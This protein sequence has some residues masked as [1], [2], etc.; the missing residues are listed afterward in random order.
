METKRQ[1]GI[2]DYPKFAD[3]ILRYRE[4]ENDP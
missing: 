2:N 4:I 1:I 3:K